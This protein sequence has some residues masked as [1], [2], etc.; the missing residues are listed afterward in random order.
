M[1]LWDIYE[2]YNTYNQQTPHIPTQSTEELPN[3]VSENFWIVIKFY[4]TLCLELNQYSQNF[5]VIRKY[6]SLPNRIYNVS[7]IIFLQR[8][9]Q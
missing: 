8:S 2:I 4:N 1:D 9:P 6:I 3:H 5:T 7:T